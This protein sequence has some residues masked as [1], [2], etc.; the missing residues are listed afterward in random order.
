MSRNPRNLSRQTV[1]RLYVASAATASAA[2]G[3][4]LGWVGAQVVFEARVAIGTALAIG[5]VIAGLLGL[6]GR[7]RPA[8]QCDVETPQRW[9]REGPIAWPVKNGASLGLGAFTRLG[10]PLWYVIPVA[11]LLSASAIF[12]AA[13]YAAYGTVRTASAWLIWRVGR[14]A[15]GYDRPLAWIERQHK[16]TTLLASGYLLGVSMSSLVVVGF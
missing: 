14:R 6:T 16:Q 13:I 1:L 12:G 8:L 15:G 4:L 10:F 7:S 9:V 2:A 5:G 3:A 11:A